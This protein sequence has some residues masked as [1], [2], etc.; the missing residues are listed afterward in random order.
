[1]E[2]SQMKNVFTKLFTVLFVFGSFFGGRAFAQSPL[3]WKTA[4]KFDNGVEPTVAV[5][6]SGLVVEFHKTQ[7]KYNNDIYYRIGKVSQVY[8]GDY[9]VSW[10]PSQTIGK[11][12]QRPHVAITKEGYV[13]LVYTKGAYTGYGTQVQMRYWA[14]QL[15]PTGDTKQA[16]VWRVKDAFYDTGQHASL[17]FN[18]NDILVDTHESA[19]NSKLFYRIGHF[20]NPSQGQFDIV[21]DSGTGGIEFDKGI[22]PSIGI[23]Q[24]NQV[25]EVHQTEKSSSYLHYR[26]GTLGSDRIVWASTDSNRYE[27]DSKTPAVALTDQGLAVEAAIRNR[28]TFSRTGI[29]NVGDPMRVD[30]STAVQI[31]WGTYAGI[32]P[33]ITTNGVVAIATWESD[34]W[35]FYNIAAIK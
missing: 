16:I 21:W 35:L 8:G 11:D 10:G 18:T 5:T 34:D 22:N 27:N 25:I 33:S 3:N 9:L 12:G 13:V 31:D 17:S 29:L 7:N 1:M 2:H 6:P 30:W 4:Q 28:Y 32:S 23:N 26:R 24:L 15:D 19:N 14:G 20:L